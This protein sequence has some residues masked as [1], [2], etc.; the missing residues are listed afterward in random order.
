MKERKAYRIIIHI[1]VNQ[2]RTHIH[3]F[4]HTQDVERPLS[5]RR[6][7]KE[8]RVGE[9]GETLRLVVRSSQ[10]IGGSVC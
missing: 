4:V 10:A 6:R 5:D 2:R 7:R 8:E 9:G 1:H 3:K